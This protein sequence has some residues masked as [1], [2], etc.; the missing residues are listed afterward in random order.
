[1]DSRWNP[2]NLYWTWVKF[3]DKVSFQMEHPGDYKVLDLVVKHI[4]CG[5][6]VESIWNSPC[7][8]NMDSMWNPYGIHVNKYVIW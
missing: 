6:H 5:I 4:P 7:G 3:S 8:M 1:M 2:W